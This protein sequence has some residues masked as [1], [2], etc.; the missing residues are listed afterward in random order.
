MECERFEYASKIE[1]R[2]SALCA[3]IEKEYG[4][5]GFYSRWT[6]AFVH[7]LLALLSVDLGAGTSW[8]E[9]GMYLYMIMHGGIANMPND[10]TTEDL[11]RALRFKWEEDTLDPDD[12]AARGYHVMRDYVM[13]WVKNHSTS[14]MRRRFV[15][16][17]TGYEYITKRITIRIHSIPEGQQDIVMPVSQACYDTVLI[18][19]YTPYFDSAPDNEDK[20]PLSPARARLYRFLDVCVE[21]AS[22]NYTNQ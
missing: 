22:A 21:H 9:A 8:N 5:D 18:P 3:M 20:G 6:Q 10:I 15:R 2:Y 4:A 14:D 7:V 11:L 16:F 19:D 1:C 12:S 17:A 13:D